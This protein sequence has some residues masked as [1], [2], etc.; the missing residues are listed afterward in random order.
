M[1]W[2]YNIH[3]SQDNNPSRKSKSK[4]TSR[5]ISHVRDTND[6]PDLISNGPGDDSQ[7]PS[8]SSDTNTN[9]QGVQGEYVQ[10]KTLKFATLNVCGLKCR[11]KYPD[12]TE[13]FTDYDFLCFVE[14]KFYSTDIVAFSGFECIS[15]PRKEFALRR[16]RGLALF[17]KIIIC[18][19]CKH[20]PS[21][22][23]YIMWV[24]IDKH[25]IDTDE[26]LTL[27]I[28]Y[29]PQ[30]LSRFNNDDGL[31]GTI[32]YEYETVSVCSSNI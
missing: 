5:S 32:S 19:F 6:P 14:T 24:Q 16:S 17:V 28:V 20:I 8:G 3:I 21:A 4:S 25:L 13:Y 11:S 27:G 30:S 9:T 12:F 22:S 29:V 1:G 2:K 18:G 23:D 15:Q 31:S 26:N 7:Q 10:H